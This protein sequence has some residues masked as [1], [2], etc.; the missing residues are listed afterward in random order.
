MVGMSILPQML[1]FTEGQSCTPEHCTYWNVP[2][3]V[4]QSYGD[5]EP[6]LGVCKHM[7]QQRS[8]LTAQHFIPNYPV[9]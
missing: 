9:M 4:L 3:A 5:P 8:A 2:A 7:A 1:L 6:H